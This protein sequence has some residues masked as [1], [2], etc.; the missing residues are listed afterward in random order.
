MSPGARQADSLAVLNRM[1]ILKS[2]SIWA[3][4]AKL[5]AELP[6][7][8]DRDLAYDRYID[9]REQSVD[10]LMKIVP[11]VK[12]L[13]T[14]AQYRI[15]PTSVAGFLDKRTLKGIRSGTA[16]GGGGGGGLGG[17][18]GGGGGGG[19]RGGGG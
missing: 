14:D 1:Y 4:A 8:Y 3:P 6:D 19:R 10:I 18:G 11:D 13:L 5:L 17:G 16:G 2:D 12:K 15:L 7:R 9:A